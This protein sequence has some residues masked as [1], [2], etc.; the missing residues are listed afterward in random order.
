M[1][2]KIKLIFLATVLLVLPLVACNYTGTD[3]APSS[4]NPQNTNTTPR[5]NPPT[6]IVSTA[7]QTPTP[8]INIETARKNEKF[9]TRIGS[10]KPHS[11][12]EY[13]E[14]VAEVMRT[15]TDYD[16]MIKNKDMWMDSGLNTTS[17]PEMYWDTKALLMIKDKQG[18]AIVAII[19][20]NPDIP[21]SMK[22]VLGDGGTGIVSWLA[23][24]VLTQRVIL[25]A[26]LPPKTGLKAELLKMQTDLDLAYTQAKEKALADARMGKPY[27]EPNKNDYILSDTKSAETAN[28]YI[29]LLAVLY[30]QQP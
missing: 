9:L 26:K 25:T 6:S 18:N 24:S 14:I 21:Q 15:R 27:V 1:S 20:S 8:S 17:M 11:V 13:V 3:N 16:E 7:K 28:K 12:S 22:P 19:N 23:R 2:S 30:L 4:I 10:A 5:P 29:D